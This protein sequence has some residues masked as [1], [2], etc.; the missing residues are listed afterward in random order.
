MFFELARPTS[1]LTLFTS[2]CLPS[3]A[4]SPQWRYLGIWPPLFASESCRAAFSELDALDYGTRQLIRLPWKVLTTLVSH[5]FAVQFVNRLM[6]ADY[7]NFD[8]LIVVPSF[9]K[10]EAVFLDVLCPLRLMP[11]C[12]VFGLTRGGNKNL[13]QRVLCYTRETGSIFM[14]RRSEMLGS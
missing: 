4:Y 13:S 5:L 7:R 1:F 3:R 2:S 10:M 6:G 14:T 11:S 12:H 9:G 8:V